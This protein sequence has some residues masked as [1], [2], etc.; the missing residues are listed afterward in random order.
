MFR[1]NYINAFVQDDIKLTPRFTLNAGVRWEWDGYPTTANGVTSNFWPSLSL[2]GP[3]PGTTPAT[4]IFNGFVVPSNY[5]GPVPAGI[6][7][8]ATPYITQTTPPW[9]N[10][11]PRLGFAWQPTSSSRFVVR[12]GAGIFYELINGIQ[13][14][15]MPMRSMPGAV[16]VNTSPLASWQQ[17]G[18]PPASVPGPPG[19]FGFT[20]RWG[21]PVTGLTSDIQQR[22]VPQD[23]TTPLTYEW[24]INTQYEFLPNWVLELGYVG[25][26]GIRQE[27]GGSVI[28][29]INWNPAQLITPTNTING[30]KCDDLTAATAC[31]TSANV[32]MRSLYPGISTLSP[33]F[34]T[35]GAYRFDALLATVRKQFSRGLQLQFAYTWS[36]GL[37]TQNYGINTPPYSILQMGPNPDYHPQRVVINYVWNLPA[38]M[39]GWRGRVLNDWTWA[40]V[41]TIQD[42]VPFTV[43][44]ANSG[45]VFFEGGNQGDLYGPA[46]ICPGVNPLTSGPIETRLGGTLSPNGYLNPAAFSDGKGASC[47]LPTVG[48]GPSGIG[49]DTG[50]GN[51]GLGT[52]ISPGQYNWDMSLSKSIK[53]RETKSLEFRGEFFNTFNHPQF[54][55][56]PVDDPAFAAQDSSSKNFNQITV[57]SVNPRLIQFVLKFLF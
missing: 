14:A 55:F 46:Q 22:L 52:F 28:N 47:S 53:I 34:A 6:T 25:S 15:Y 49:G 29:A 16:S 37:I 18:V 38:H 8:N 43:Y 9:H 40:G 12:G 27:Q 36:K 2:A 4:G 32:N 54:S 45:V 17:P 24:N 5:Q 23:L 7:K 19:G 30:I 51:I 26:H 33:L 35:N 21:D 31:N 13:G 11:A 56:N 1:L 57:S 42:G 20:P 48:A 41:T 50:F 44:D 3:L 10:F 39:N